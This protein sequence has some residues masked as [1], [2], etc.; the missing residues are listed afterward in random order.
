MNTSGENR[1]VALYF[2]SPS[3]ISAKPMKIAARLV[4]SKPLLACAMAVASFLLAPIV[5][6]SDKGA[7]S[8]YPTACEPGV[9]QLESLDAMPNGKYSRNDATSIRRC[10]F[11]GLV[12]MDEFRY[13]NHAGETVFRGISFGH[14]NEASDRERIL[15]VM[16]GET[17]LTLID[18]EIRDGRYYTEGEGFDAP[19]AFLERS[20]TKYPDANTMAFKMD[21]SYDD[22]ASWI[23]PFNR[24]EG[25]RT[26]TTLPP[27][28]Q[29]LDAEL[30]AMPYARG[31]SQWHYS[32]RRQNADGENWLGY[33]DVESSIVLDGFAETLEIAEY[34]RDGTL[35]ARYIAYSTLDKNGEQWRTVKWNID[36]AEASVS[37]VV[38]ATASGPV[39]DGRSGTETGWVT[40][41]ENGDKHFVSTVTGTDGSIETTIAHRISDVGTAFSD[42]PTAPYPDQ[43]CNDYRFNLGHWRLDARSMKPDRSSVPAVGYLYGYPIHDG[44]GVAAEMHVIHETGEAFRGTTMRT[45]GSDGTW[46]ITW[47]LDNGPTGRSGLSD[48]TNPDICEEVWS[49]LTNP[50]G[51]FDNRLRLIDITPNSFDVHSD[52]VYQ[53]G[54]VTVPDVWSY[55]AHRIEQ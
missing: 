46:N 42:A 12:S 18:G 55:S 22:G 32:I 45:R 11:E 23:T 39:T 25:E 15:W 36:E 37:T 8:H 16:V 6:A 38:P 52:H 51:N 20:V 48:G 34:D 3:N 19:G 7:E 41:R 29:T 28:P 9:W 1:V 33:A 40:F 13:L 35:N 5:S 17:G 27:L 43:S 50:H 14:Q 30:A 26:S 44:T 53:S 4:I 47:V 2:Y 49:D 54:G 24:I 31:R 21:R 10:L